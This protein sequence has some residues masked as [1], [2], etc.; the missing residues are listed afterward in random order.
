MMAFRMALRRP[1]FLNRQVKTLLRG[2]A[3]LALGAALLAG[4]PAMADEP[5]SPAVGKPLQAAIAFMRARNFSKAIAAVH[6]A[7]GAP[8]KTPHENAL[9]AQTKA[10]IASQSGDAATAQSI[11]TQELN[12]GQA[13]GVEAQKMM[14]GLVSIAFKQKNYPQ[15]VYWSDRYLKA[16]GTDPAMHTYLIQ[17][18]YLQGKYADA[19]KLQQAQIAQETH[20]GRPP[21]EGQLQLLYS[22]Q[23]KLGDKLGQLATIKQLITFYPKPDYWLNVIDNVRAKPGFPDR[24]SLDVYRL[25]FS[26]G[27][28]NK[29]EDA[30]DMA[31]LAI[32]AKL[33]G[34]AKDVVDKSY[35]GG[36]LGTGAEAPRQAR[37]KALVDKTFDA[38]KA[39]LGKEDAAAADA[40][41]GNALLALGRTYVS[42]GMF[43]KGIPMMEQ[44][45]HKDALSHPDDAKLHLG[46]AY[47]KAG[48]QAK[49]V[50]MLK[51]VH[52]TDGTA[53]LAQLWILRFRTK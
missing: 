35:A 42:Y 16:G 14:L 18:Y 17:G 41:D 47:W 15:V 38:D 1:T 32:Q 26:L 45:I 36:L 33:P 3:A 34:E 4:A 40:H 23:S 22:C 44:A 37:L 49:A 21:E 24:L 31:E 51:T 52:G 8:N 6:Q 29:A 53:D 27:L 30:M 50:A 20:G 48:Q 9:I 28:V 7:E 10:S 39:Q 2:S 46:L 12:S 11:F 5:V 19:E 25:E 43:D 13:T